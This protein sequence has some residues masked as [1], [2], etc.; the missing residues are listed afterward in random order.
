MAA[1]L[2]D[3]VPD[4]Q[5]AVVLE[6]IVEKAEDLNAC[7]RDDVDVP[8]KNKP[9]GAQEV[10]VRNKF[11]GVN[12]IDTY[13]RTGLYKAEAPFGLGREGAGEVVGVGSEVPESICKLGDNVAYLASSTY[14]QYS[15]A[16]AD[17]VY[18]APADVGLDV[19]T[20]LLT[21]GLTAQYLARDSFPL[22]PGKACL[23]QAAAGGTGQLL[24]Q[25]AKA[26]GATVIGTCS[27]RKS[28][29]AKAVGC[30]LVLNY[31]ELSQDEVVDRVKEATEG[32]GVHVAYD[33]VGK[34]TYQMSMQC[35]RK[36]GTLVLFGNASGAVPP[37]DPL[38]L[39]KQGSIFLTRPI[40][41]HHIEDQADFA[42]RMDELVAWYKDGSVKVTVQATLPL[43]EVSESHR[44]L[45]SGST[46]GKVLL[47]TD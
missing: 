27:K 28:D 14:A 42:S 9:L 30:D 34:A 24:V 46:Q 40:M 3:G 15:A 10:L 44:L 17:R 7:L 13:F 25:V 41:G 4:K 22:G 31:D 47:K 38:D 45:E 23:V 12:F 6:H 11:A 36:R 39:T 37:I 33:G 26:L 19:L 29:I 35:V 16:S 21:Q 1:T 2:A 8:G 5:M 18:K 32:K 20:T 43:S